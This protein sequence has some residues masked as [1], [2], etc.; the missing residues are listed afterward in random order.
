MQ[1]DKLLGEVLRDFDLTREPASQDQPSTTIVVRAALKP[2]HSHPSLRGARLEFDAETKVVRKLVLERTG[3][4]RP[5]ATITYTLVDTQAHPDRSF[6]LEG[7]LQ[8]PYEI[9]TR[10]YEPEKRRELV[11]R[12]LAVQ[13]PERLRTTSRPA[14]RSAAQT[15]PAD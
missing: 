9:Y 6:E 7:H 5:V 10:D 11:S 3:S 12:W 13:A 1:P 2:G 4:G 15:H 8:A 14:T